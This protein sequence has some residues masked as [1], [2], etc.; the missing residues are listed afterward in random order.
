MLL[1]YMSLAACTNQV[2]TAVDSNGPLET[3]E[4]AATTALPT[5]TTPPL[6]N[7]T[8]SPTTTPTIGPTATQVQPKTPPLEDIASLINAG[9]NMPGLENLMADS[10]TLRP[11]PFAP[12]AMSPQQALPDLRIYLHTTSQIEVTENIPD[13]IDVAEWVETPADFVA[14]TSGWGSSGTIEGL[15]LFVQMETDMV[16]SGLILS[17]NGFASAPVLMAVPPPVDLTYRVGNHIFVVS[18]DGTTPVF[19]VE[20]NAEASYLINPTNTH[21]LEVQVVADQPNRVEQAAL[22]DLATGAR[23][24]VELP[25]IVAGSRLGWVNE[26]IVG[27]NVW[28][29]EADM[30]GQTP[31]R[32]AIFNIV[33]REWMLL[34]DDHA[35]LSQVSNGRIVYVNEDEWVVWRPT[36]ATRQSFS[37]AG[38][39][40]L[41]HSEQQWI[42]LTSGTIAIANPQGRTDLLQYRAFTPNGRFLTSVVWSPDDTWVALQPATS[43]LEFNG[44]WLY[45]VHGGE[46]MH[47]GNGTSSA[48]WLDGQ[49]VLFNAV[50][51]GALQMHAYNIATAERVRI[52]VPDSSVPIHFR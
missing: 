11:L 20:D 4:A 12:Q 6:V 41:A 47:L 5:Q 10:F 48:L 34:A 22:I 26:Q 13:R 35:T 51:D 28:L 2:E 36:G 50:V 23:Q 15:M 24:L 16:W 9:E 37:G 32:P 18:D 39:P 52:D 27:M 42:L 19:Q 40:I 25:Y 7:A 21:V 49:T 29:D 3:T 45:S 38:L 30:I 14:Y 33:S 17:A 1:V 31:G 44:L 46:M 8:A 43:E